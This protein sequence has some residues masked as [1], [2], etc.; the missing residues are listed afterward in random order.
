MVFRMASV[1]H[2]EAAWYE[3]VETPVR[4]AEAVALVLKGCV[5]VATCDNC[6]LTGRG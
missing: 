4:E 5:S 6:Y 3:G 1:T 2:D